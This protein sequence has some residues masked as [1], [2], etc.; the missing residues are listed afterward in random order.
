MKGHFNRRLFITGLG[1]YLLPAIHSSEA[2]AKSKF[3]TPG[4]T[5]GPTINGLAIGDRVA[6]YAASMIGQAVGQG[7]SAEFVNAALAAAGAKTGIEFAWGKSVPMSAARRGEILQF[8][9]GSEYYRRDNSVWNSGEENLA[10]ILLGSSK[11]GFFE[12]AHQK[13]SDGFV[14]R[15]TLYLSTPRSGEFYEFRPIPE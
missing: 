15:E 10:A 1:A 5:E 3:N 14:V 8:Q 11:D 2:N 9:M 7:G 13:S 4:V 12:V 6:D